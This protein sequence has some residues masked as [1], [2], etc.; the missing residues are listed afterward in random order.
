MADFPNFY[1]TERQNFNG[2][3]HIFE[4]QQSNGNTWNIVRLKRKW[5]IEDGGRR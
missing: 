3:R 4:A 2:Y 5:K 1:A